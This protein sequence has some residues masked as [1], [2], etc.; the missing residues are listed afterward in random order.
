M[1]GY[2]GFRFW[3]EFIKPGFFILGLTAIQW[4]CLLMLIYYAKYF[5]RL[6]KYKEVVA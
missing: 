6:W 5:K 4:A 1:V 2:L 3:V